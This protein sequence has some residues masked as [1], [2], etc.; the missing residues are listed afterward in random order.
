[1]TANDQSG[2]LVIDAKS[3]CLQYK[4]TNYDITH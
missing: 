4:I 1:M 2:H 3:I